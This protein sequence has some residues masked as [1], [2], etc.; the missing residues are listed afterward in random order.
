MTVALPPASFPESAL[1][2]LA[3]IPAQVSGPATLSAPVVSGDFLALLGL[4]LEA[5]T[6][7]AAPPAETLPAR[8]FPCESDLDD[9]AEPNEAPPIAVSTD[10]LPSD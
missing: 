1:L 2:L 8:A 7:P 4:L 9:R 10:V 3:P 5:Q 6:A